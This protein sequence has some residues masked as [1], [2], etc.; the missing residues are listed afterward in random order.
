MCRIQWQEVKHRGD[1]INTLNLEAA[2]V[3]GMSWK[4]EKFLWEALGDRLLEKFWY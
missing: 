1:S 2:E 3:S 4:N